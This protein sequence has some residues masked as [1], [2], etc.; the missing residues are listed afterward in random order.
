MGALDR[1]YRSDRKSS[2]RSL[3][4]CIHSRFL[5]LHQS[6]PQGLKQ[7]VYRETM[8]PYLF[9]IN[10]AIIGKRLQFGIVYT[11]CFISH[12]PHFGVKERVSWPAYLKK[13]GLSTI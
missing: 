9:H 6:Y 13:L 12:I 4:C 11:S 2:F 1:A 10:M 8:K 3:P 5:G 7:A